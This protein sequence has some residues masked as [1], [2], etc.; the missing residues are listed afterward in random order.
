MR[1]VF[2]GTPAT[3]VPSLEALVASR[4]EVVAVVTRPDAPAGR[5]RR[6]TRSPVGRWADD[7][8][9]PVLA[10]ARPRPGSGRAR[11]PTPDCCSVVA[12]GAWCPGG[13][14]RPAA[15]LGELHFSVLPAWRGAAPVQRAIMAVTRWSGRRPSGW[16]ETL[17]TDRSTGA[18]RVGRPPDTPETCS[19][20]WPW[21][22]R[23]SWWP[24]WTG[25]RT[26]RSMPVPRGPR[27][28]R[29][30]PRSPSRTPRWTGPGRRSPWTG[31]SGPVPPLRAPGPPGGGNGSNWGRSGSGPRPR[32]VPWKPGSWGVPAGGPGRD[33]DPTG[34]PGPGP[35]V[36][37]AA[38]AG[39]RLGAWGAGHDGR[40][41]RMTS[42]T[43]R[44]RGPRPR[45]RNVA[46]RNVDPVRQLAFAALRTVAERDAYANLVLPAINGEARLP[47]RRGLRHR[48]DLRLPPRPGDLRRGDRQDRRPAPG[49]HRR[50]STGRPADGGA[51]DPGHAGTRPRRG[52]RHGR[53]G[54]RRDRLRGVRFRQRRPS[55]DDHPGPGRLVGRGRS[56]RGGGPGRPP[57]VAT[58]SGVDVRPW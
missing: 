33:R 12:Y 4:H 35:A 3:A 30:P 47:T 50:R 51:P 36:R 19:P 24:P 25:S 5:G 43:P 17:D 6:A 31:W 48:A 58:T 37:T 1:L 28:S 32:R 57:A 29:T 40:T 23:N 56:C 44:D 11:R 8:G 16:K 39:G 9:L 7:H 2:A 53:P 10:L 27:A 38:D 41:A 42:T 52:R 18:H 26:G 13:A 49:R 15:G 54:P 34:A 21:P 20:G 55:P 22:G 46:R 45:T 14:R